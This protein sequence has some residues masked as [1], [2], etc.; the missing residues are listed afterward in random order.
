MSLSEKTQ[1]DPQMQRRTF[2]K[3][4]L[5]GLAASTL[6]P[7]S[8]F[9]KSIET[10]HRTISLYNLHTG[11]SLKTTYWENGVYHA[12]ALKE[13]NHLLRDHRNNARHNIDARLFDLL[14]KIQQRSGS[15]QA[16]HVI[17]GYRSPQTNAMLHNTTSGV[18]SKSLHT[19]GKAIDIRLPGVA[20]NDLRQ[21][22]LQQKGGGVGFYPK[23]NF[24]HVDTGRVRYW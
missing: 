21:I 22:A 4:G 10:R 14:H 9:A 19:Q 6:T 8:V 23:S 11:E 7:T 16:F 24:V 17:S 12:E 15:Q 13:L 18:A 1:L 5:A 3:L 20:L 2:L